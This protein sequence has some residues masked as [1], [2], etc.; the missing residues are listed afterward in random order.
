MKNV[1]R[2]VIILFVSVLMIFS[3]GFAFAEEKTSTGGTAVGANTTAAKT[4][5]LGAQSA[6]GTILGVSKTTALI[7]GGVVVAAAGVAV[8]SGSGGGGGGGH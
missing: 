6:G 5:T 3:G 7:V 8:A 4:A 2:T 1:A